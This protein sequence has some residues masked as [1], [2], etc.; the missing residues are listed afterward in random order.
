MR[1]Q[2]TGECLWYSEVFMV[3]ELSDHQSKKQ[4]PAGGMLDILVSIIFASEI[5][6]VIPIK[7]Y[8]Q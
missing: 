3:T 5:V 1:T 6:E 8:R 4:V 2:H 7:K